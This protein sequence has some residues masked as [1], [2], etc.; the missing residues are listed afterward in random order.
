MLVTL[1]NLPQHPESV[2]INLLIPIP[3]TPLEGAEPLDP[4]EF[5][6]TIA[7]ARIMM[8]RSMVRLSAGRDAM[9][10]ELQALCFFAGAN[11][12][13]LG[14]TLLTAGNPAED[15][16]RALFSKLGLAPMPAEGIA[17]QV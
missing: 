12:I 10:D 2:P 14:G 13:F 16:D 1:A 15:K 17:A 4:L 5:V 8:P 3:G 6:R 11:S 7:L 9:S